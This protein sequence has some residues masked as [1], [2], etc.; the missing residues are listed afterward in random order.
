MFQI[1]TKVQVLSLYR[2]ILRKSQKQLVYTNYETF[3]SRLKNEFY[4]TNQVLRIENISKR[5]ESIAILWEVGKKFE[6]DLGGIR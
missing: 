4:A 6:I 1:P 2:S 3:R 5:E